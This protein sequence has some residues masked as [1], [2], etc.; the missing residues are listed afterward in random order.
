MPTKRTRARSG[1]VGG[2]ANEAGGQYRS[3]VAALF[4]A[5]GLN[6]LPFPG[7]PIREADAIVDGVALETDFAIDDLLVQLHVGRLFIQAKRTLSFS[8][9]MR[10]VISQWLLAVRDPEFRQTEDLVAA[11]AE[12]LSNGVRGLAEALDRRRLGATVFST[13]E[14]R[15][16]DWLRRTLLDRGSLDS[17]LE[18]VLSRAVILPLQVGST[19]QEHSERGRLLLDGHVVLKDRGAQAWRELVAIAGDA[20]RLRLSYRI[21][22]WLER[23]R[24]QQIPLMADSEASRAAYLEKRRTAV[25]RYRKRLQHRGSYVDLTSIGLPLPLIALSEMD[26]T[27]HVREPQEDER[28]DHDLLWSFRLRGRVVLTGLPGGGKSTAVSKTVSE[29]ARRDHWA[30]PVLASLRRLADREHFRKRPL[31]DE[32]LDVAV[33]IVEAID[34]PLV[35]DALNDALNTGG[36]A[37]FLDGLD[38][39][40]DRSLSL[41]SDIAELLEGVH[42]D[43]DVLVATRDVAYADAKILGFSDL[44]LCQPRDADRAVNVVL[45]AIASHRGLAAIDEWVASRTEWV[46]RL[47]TVDSQLRETPLIPILL[48]SLAADHQANDLPRTRSLILDQVLRNIV[49]RKELK[50]EIRIS[51]IHEGHEAEVVLNGFPIIASA[52]AKRGGA[53]PRANLVDPL[54]AYLRR[55]W[56]LPPATAQATATQ[57]LVFWD[58]SGIFVASGPHKVVAPR[59]RL[60]LEIGAAL[61]AV[62]LSP[63]DAISW[64]DETALSDDKGE[65]LILAAGLSQAIAE[66]LIDSACRGAEERDDR[67]AL[68]AARALAQG[69]TAS[70]T[71]VRQLTQRLLPL[72]RP[73]DEGAWRVCQAIVRLPVPVDLEMPILDTIH[74][75]FPGDYAIVATAL[76]S[77]DWKWPANRRNETLERGLR[78]QRLSGL[79][80]QSMFVDRAFMRLLENAATILLPDRPDLAPVVAKAS[81]HAS[82]AVAAKLRGLLLRNGHYE[83]AKESFRSLSFSSKQQAQLSSRM[84]QMVRDVRETLQILAALSPHAVISL[85]QERRLAELASLVETLN[86]DDLS[87]WLSEDEWR[88]LRKE[89]LLLIATLGGFDNGVVAKQAAIVE[90]EAAFDPQNTYSPF[91][92]LSAVG[93]RANLNQWD[94]VTDVEGSR[95]LLLRIL[96]SRSGSALVAAQALAEHPDRGGTADI[97]GDTLCTLPRESVRPAVWAYLNL[98]SDLTGGTAALARWD[99]ENVREAVASLDTLV[100]EGRPTSVGIHLAKDPVRQVQLAAITQFKSAASRQPTPELFSLLEEIESSQNTSF[101]CYHCGTLCAAHHDSCPS[102]H[103]V[104]QRPSVAAGEI[105]ENR[106]LATP[107]TTS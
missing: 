87:A 31:R 106:R 14:S 11:A 63:S 41:A 7:L 104:T 10:E 20:A 91:Y 37:L 29:W 66:A 39:A 86:L 45:R 9:P 8:R 99:N 64:V 53:T 61:H 65:T 57:L 43:T 2:A 38:E 25:A 3:A 105:L 94:R 76:A 49:T 70:D 62:S 88:P 97:I 101:I 50:R 24:R 71:S 48:A 15:A 98:V 28:D 90:R 89:W 17:E 85:A 72:L 42:P 12:N 59:L 54:S 80:R 96:H 77:L 79:G 84:D 35:L 68:E 67:L 46:K 40:A 18:L 26:A 52:L 19:G 21:A 100:E 5:Y 56:G 81:D 30:L 34:R 107:S 92:D 58:E 95:A 51:G 44:Q 74:A 16:L 4:V 6:G 73:G 22:A 78:L 55:D 102:C 23:L 32:V 103:V 93:H 33:E 13:R 60:F 69:G 75:S 83:L 47:I 27:I 82:S 36:A 1:S